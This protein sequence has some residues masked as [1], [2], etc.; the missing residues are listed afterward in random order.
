[1]SVV[2]VS[3]HKIEPVLKKTA[4]SFNRDETIS[5]PALAGILTSELL[6]SYFLFSE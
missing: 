3:I 2:L 5:S 6:N 1:M 4:L